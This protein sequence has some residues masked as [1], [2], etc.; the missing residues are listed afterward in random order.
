MQEYPTR[1]GGCVG[2]GGSARFRTQA[3]AAR[4][5]F[6]KRRILRSVLTSQV[7]GCHLCRRS[8][9]GQDTA[10]DVHPGAE[11]PGNAGTGSLRNTPRG[12][13]VLRPDGP[14]VTIDDVTYNSL[15]VVGKEVRRNG[16]CDY[17]LGQCGCYAGR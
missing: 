2:G 16:V 10:Q 17:V 8:E 13:R 7:R 9:N 4:S 3:E 14:T 1:P 6:R 11:G 5:R 15:P 12:E